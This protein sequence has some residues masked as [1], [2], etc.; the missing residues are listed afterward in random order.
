[1]AGPAF[2]V[3]MMAAPEYL[4]LGPLASAVAFWGGLIVFFLTIIVVVAISLHE[5]GKRKAVF[6]PII[7]MAIGALTFGAGAA[8]YFWPKTQIS[9]TAKHQMAEDSKVKPNVP[10][11][12]IPG[13]YGLYIDQTSHGTITGV[14][15][16]GWR[17][18]GVI[19]R[20][21]DINVT[22]SDFRQ[23][24]P[25]PGRPLVKVEKPKG[26][27]KSLTN[28]ELIAKADKIAGEI[29]DLSHGARDEEFIHK[30]LPTV[31]EIV[32]EI[33]WRIGKRISFDGATLETGAYVVATGNTDKPAALQSAAA[34]L[35]N[36][37]SRLPKN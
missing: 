30:Y 13:G 33:I 32:A 4:H 5:E 24:G 36:A 18:G 10:G 17:G 31:R 25:T 6:G 35:R 20:S 9:K 26:K 34:F 22:N 8:W 28:K 23:E 27:F 16:S 11:S 1:M 19:R 7:V 21:T 37:A 3:A 15:A 14:V 12:D 2:G 29:D